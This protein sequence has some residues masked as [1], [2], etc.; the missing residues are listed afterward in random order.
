MFLG[1]RKNRKALKLNLTIKNKS[2]TEG[3][4]FNSSPKIPDHVNVLQLNVQSLRKHVEDL[5]ALVHCLESLPY[6]LF[7][8][9]R[10]G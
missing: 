10:R 3:D 1:H 8:S 6:I 4:F 2:K 5:E 9:L 7:V